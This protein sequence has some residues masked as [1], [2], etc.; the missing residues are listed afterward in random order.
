[1]NNIAEGFERNS[2]A[3]FLR[4]LMISKGSSGEVRSQLYVA[5]DQEY[6]PDSTFRELY[7]EVERISRMIAALMDYLQ[8]TEIR[9]LRYKR[10]DKPET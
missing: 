1:M 9:G 5:L 3:E 7:A 6:I 10:T 8:R 4:Y 2:N